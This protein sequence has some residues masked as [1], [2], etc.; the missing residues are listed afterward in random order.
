MDRPK[1]GSSKIL[2]P[3]GYLVHPTE[4]YSLQVVRTTLW[5]NFPLQKLEHSSK[6]VHGGVHLQKNLK[7]K[8]RK[9]GSDNFLEHFFTAVIL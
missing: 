5:N 8:L 3:Q 7:L 2:G 9:Q 6:K 1:S 4:K